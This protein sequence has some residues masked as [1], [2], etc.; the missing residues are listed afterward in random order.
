MLVY[1]IIIRLP[2]NRDFAGQ[3]HLENPSGKR[4]AGPFPVGGRADNKLAQDNGNPDRNRLLP[5]G[6]TPLGEYQILQI[7]ASGT[8]TAYAA[9][10]F[11]A[12]GIVLL[13]PKDGEA[14]LADA[15]GR[16]GFFIQGGAVSR[17]GAL[18]PTEGSLRLF[19]GHQRNFIAALRRLGGA[20]C[21][22]LVVET[23]S[24]KATHRIADTAS[25]KPAVNFLTQGK[26]IP[27][28][29]FAGPAAAIKLGMSR[30]SW[31]RQMLLVGG[32][33]PFIPGMLTF[34]PNAADEGQGY[35]GNIHKNAPPVT[36]LPDEQL[37]LRSVVQVFAGQYDLPGNPVPLK[38]VLHGDHTLVASLPGKPDSVLV[39]TRGTTFNFKDINGFSIEFKRD[40]SGKVTG[41]ALDERGT[42][43]VLKR[44]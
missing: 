36:P 17:K 23:V 31:M 13:Q 40:A 5:F 26:G 29:L 35:G 37:L 24:G 30:R 34:S 27:A 33:S 43:L 21:Q 38:I 6:D 18:R 14:V 16:F 28:E 15:N 8:G 42:V 22:C 19:N 12:A 20:D 41:C 44:R 2:S 4:I 32:V 39:P 10:E 3:L 9:E 25:F 1:K 11:G 7:I